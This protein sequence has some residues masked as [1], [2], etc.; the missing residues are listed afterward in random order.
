MKA[1][2]IKQPWA[3]LICAGYKDIENR[4]WF[5]GRKVA[6]GAVNFTIPLPM[7]IYVHA[8]KQSDLSEETIAF[9][10]ERANPLT[11]EYG[12][13]WKDVLN[14][15]AIIGEVDITGC[16]KESQSPWFVGRYGFTLAN[17]ILYDKPIP[18]RGQLGFFEV[19]LSTQE[20]NHG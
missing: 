19:V 13:T 18:Y 10:K 1:L 11:H 4:D 9:I 8:G 12:S 7:R 3:W 14:F 16:V 17:P 5:I 20:V 6:S 2:S 15:G